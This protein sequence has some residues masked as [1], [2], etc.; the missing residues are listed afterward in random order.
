MLALGFAWHGRD[1]FGWFESK[2][3]GPNCI[4]MAEQWFLSANEYRIILRGLSSSSRG[5]LNFSSTSM[6]RR[7]LRDGKT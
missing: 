3:P 5:F 4:S 1:E 6:K 7:S 2:N